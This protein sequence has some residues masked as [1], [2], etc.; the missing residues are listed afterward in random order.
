MERATNLSALIHLSILLYNSRWNK[1]YRRGIDVWAGFL[2]KKDESDDAGCSERA[3][4][5]LQHIRPD[6]T[7]LCKD[8]SFFFSFLLPVKWVNDLF[9]VN[10]AVQWKIFDEHV[11]ILMNAQKTQEL[12]EETRGAGLGPRDAIDPRY[13]GRRR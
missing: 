6:K 11:Y 8:L 4:T 5:L 9:A 3:V 12:R 7:P 2:N 1:A 13:P 10:P